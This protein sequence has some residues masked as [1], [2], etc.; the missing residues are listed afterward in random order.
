MKKYLLIAA[1]AAGAWWLWKKKCTGKSSDEMSLENLRMGIANE[2]YSVKLFA[3]DNSQ[4]FAILTGKDTDGETKETTK[5]I[6]FAT[7]EALKADGVPEV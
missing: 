5:Q 2:W 4:Y 6:S 3:G 7:Y 1:V